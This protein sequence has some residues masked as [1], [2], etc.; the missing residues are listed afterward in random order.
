MVMANRHAFS[1]ARAD[2]ADLVAALGTP[3]Q[4]YKTGDKDVDVFK[5]DPNGRA[6]G[7]KVAI[8]AFNVAADAVTLRRW[9][10]VRGHGNGRLRGA[11]A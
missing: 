9:V 8:G 5:L 2:R 4:S 1:H 6:P 10:A 3:V 7:T 11:R